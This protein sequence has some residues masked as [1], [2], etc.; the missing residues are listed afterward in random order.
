MHDCSKIIIF[1]FQGECELIDGSSTTH[2]RMWKLTSTFDGDDGSPDTSLSSPYYEVQNIADLAVERHFEKSLATFHAKQAAAA[3]GAATNIAVALGESISKSSLDLSLSRTQPPFS[4]SPS[5][6][7]SSSDGSILFSPREDASVGPSFNPKKKWL[8]QYGDDE[9][10]RNDEDGR[11]NGVWSSNN[12]SWNTPNASDST[13]IDKRSKSCPLLLNE[14][15]HSLKA[16]PHCRPKYNLSSN[17]R[18]SFV[19][20]KRFF[21]HNLL[22]YIIF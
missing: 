5:S 21:N 20:K 18:K 17:V 1:K 14:S 12:C 4:L 3:S 10:T 15:A 6:S 8:A 22:K 16:P 7:N 9:G 2:K 13:N 19:Q 11:K